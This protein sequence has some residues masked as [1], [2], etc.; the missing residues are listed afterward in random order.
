MQN[1][2]EIESI[3]WDEFKVEAK[4]TPERM[5]TLSE[6]KLKMLMEYKFELEERQR[7]G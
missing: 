3:T 5:E 4:L 1:L 7:V 2:K 6:D